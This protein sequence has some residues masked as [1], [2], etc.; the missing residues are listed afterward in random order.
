MYIYS[1]VNLHV[2][3]KE[4]KLYEGRVYL[5][6]WGWEGRDMDHIR[7][8]YLLNSNRMQLRCMRLCSNRKKY[9][10]PARKVIVHIAFST[11]TDRDR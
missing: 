8:D 9:S 4:L 2:F 11:E 5:R 6:G 3:T 1:H 10:I 7:V